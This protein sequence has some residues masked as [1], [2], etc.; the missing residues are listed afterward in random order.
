MGDQIETSQTDTDREGNQAQDNKKFFFVLWPP[1]L[2]QMKPT[3][4][5]PGLTE[6]IN[7]LAWI[8]SSRTPRYPP[9]PPTTLPA[10]PRPRPESLPGGDRTI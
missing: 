8:P 9:L 6:R 5:N 1:S 4:T 7:R 10:S 3:H 2:H